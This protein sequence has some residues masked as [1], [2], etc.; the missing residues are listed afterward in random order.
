MCNMCNN[1]T[2]YVCFK[3]KIKYRRV[4]F[5]FIFLFVSKTNVVTL[6]HMCKLQYIQ[7]NLYLYNIY[8]YIQ[9][10]NKFYVPVNAYNFTFTLLTSFI[11]GKAVHYIRHFKLVHMLQTCDHKNRQKFG[12]ELSNEWN[13][14]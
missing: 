14:W 10:M 1:V 3:N 13:F 9:S 4:I 6:L 5:C 12:E 11:P 7:K 2:I 8:I